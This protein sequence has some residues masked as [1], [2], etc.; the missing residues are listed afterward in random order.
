MK[1]LLPV[2]G[3]S[4]ADQTL[5]WAGSTFDKAATEYTLLHVIPIIPEL[6]MEEYDVENAQKLLAGARQIL[7]SQGCTVAQT[8]HQHGDAVGHI[9][10]TA[11]QIKADLV[12]IGSHGRRGLSKIL[13]GSVSEAVLEHCKRPVI[14]FKNA[15][16]A[17]PGEHHG[18]LPANTML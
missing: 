6:P 10:E 13:L 17:S 1:I 2:D 16:P 11:D 15:V 5:H 12:I 14:I 4:C 8:R 7:E 18:L 9:C 3:S